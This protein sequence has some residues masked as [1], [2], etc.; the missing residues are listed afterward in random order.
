M[1][2]KQLAL[3]NKYGV[4]SPESLRAALVGLVG[5]I[6]PMPATKLDS[7]AVRSHFVG[8]VRQ[9]LNAFLFDINEVKPI[10]VDQIQLAAWAVYH[11]R[12]QLI[13]GSAVELLTENDNPIKVAWSEG[14]TDF[15]TPELLQALRQDL[16]QCLKEYHQ[17]Q[18]D[19][20]E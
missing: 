4:Y 2:V 13:H 19:N 8:L 6:P 18:G 17:R 15:P 12:Y 16:E 11:A 9:Y 1:N 20:D 14:I 5:I 10:N 7:S 3:A